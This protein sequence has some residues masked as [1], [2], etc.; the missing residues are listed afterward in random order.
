MSKWHQENRE[1]LKE[2]YRKYYLEHKEKIIER[3]RQHYQA[4][5]EERKKYIWQWQKDNLDKIRVYR[6]RLYSK[7]SH[8]DRVNDW[9]KNNPDKFRVLATVEKVKR[10]ARKTNAKG[11]FNMVMV[12]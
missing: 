8:S 6:D 3:S 2:Y 4:N 12:L 11:Y 1:R 10:R 5:A 7:R 9:R